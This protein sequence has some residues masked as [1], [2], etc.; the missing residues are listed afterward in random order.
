MVA[1]QA[2]SS[3]RSIPTYIMVEHAVLQASWTATGRTQ[4]PKRC[5]SLLQACPNVSDGEALLFPLHVEVLDLGPAADGTW[6]Y[7]SNVELLWCSLQC[8]WT[9]FQYRTSIEQTTSQCQ[10]RSNKLLS[11]WGSA[12]RLYRALKHGVLMPMLHLLTVM[13]RRGGLLNCKQWN[14]WEI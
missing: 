9:M 6:A 13:K 2:V 1:S 4:A 12:S 10:P 14:R 3:H 8:R 11:E 7:N 5:T